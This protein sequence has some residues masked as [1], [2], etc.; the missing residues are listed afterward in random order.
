MERP[1]QA[2]A[3]LEALC[4]QHMREAL[5]HVH[6]AM[7]PVWHHK[8]LHAWCAKQVL[9]ASDKAAVSSADV[10]AAHSGLWAEVQLVERSS[11]RL[12]D[13]LCGAI[14]YQE[15]LFPGGSMG[16]VLPV[17]EQAT[18]T[19]S[20][21]YNGWPLFTVGTMVTST[22]VANFYNEQ[23]LQ[24]LAPSTTSALWQQSRRWSLCWSPV[25]KWWCS[26]WVLAPVARHQACCRCSSTDAR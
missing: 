13:A 4:E 6:E 18:S 20:N 19:T 16:A 12:R 5:Q 21:F 11:P 9:V 22:T 24:W 3:L 14:A 1:V 10:L 23:L 26:R 25:G 15:L 8:L 17:Y 2:Y 7:V